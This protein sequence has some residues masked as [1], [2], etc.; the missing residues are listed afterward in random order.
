MCKGRLFGGANMVLPSFDETRRRCSYLENIFVRRSA[1]IGAK[2]N[3]QKLS[4]SRSLRKMH[5]FQGEF[6][7]S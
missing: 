3:G 7:S 5:S 6:P 2:S 1:E 4:V